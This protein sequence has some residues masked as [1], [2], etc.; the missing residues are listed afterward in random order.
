MSFG[1]HTYLSRVIVL[2]IPL[3]FFFNLALSPGLF[4]CLLAFSCQRLQ[5]CTFSSVF[6]FRI[7]IN[8]HLFFN[9]SLFSF[10]LLLSFCYQPIP[11]RVATSIE[12]SI[13]AWCLLG[14]RS[15]GGCALSIRLGVFSPLLRLIPSCRMRAS[16]FSFYRREEP[17]GLRKRWTPGVFNYPPLLLPGQLDDNAG[18][19]NCPGYSRTHCS[20]Q[21]CWLQ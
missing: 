21:R 14:G 18:F 19:N 20:G 15:G 5:V 3:L 1:G 4:C 7:Q 13:L 16:G 11:L 10:Y 6:L 12:T 17:S 8:L 2:Q 9:F